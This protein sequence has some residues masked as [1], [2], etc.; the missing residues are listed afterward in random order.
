[1]KRY[2]VAYVTFFDNELT[3]ETVEASTP[4]EAVR[5]HSKLVDINDKFRDESWDELKDMSSDE[6]QGWFFDYDIL[7]AALEIS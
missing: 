6:L 4:C 1:M 7:V 5:K 3:L 2:V